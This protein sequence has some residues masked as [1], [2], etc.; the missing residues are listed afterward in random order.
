MMTRLFCILIATMT[1][2]ADAAGS[3]LT[4]ND[5]SNPGRLR[6]RNLLAEQEGFEMEL[7]MPSPDIDVNNT[8][9]ESKNDESENTLDFGDWWPVDIALTTG[10]T[11]TDFKSSYAGHDSFC[12]IEGK[13]LCKLNELCPGRPKNSLVAYNAYTPGYNYAPGLTIPA[14]IADDDI[15]VAYN[16]NDIFRQDNC[17]VYGGCDSPGNGWVQI[18]KWGHSSGPGICNTH[19]ELAPPV[20]GTA[21]ACP[22][23]GASAS[24]TAY[25]PIA[26]VCCGDL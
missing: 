16:T 25:T 6:L 10:A 4:P 11:I 21:E 15:W 19:C 8:N 3:K 23:W 18:G 13:R 7:Q 1:S 12:A 5:E 26:I 17:N 20:V 24:N 22:G 14:N 9:P 2:A